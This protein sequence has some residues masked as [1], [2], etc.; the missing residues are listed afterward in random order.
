[1]PAV[2][3]L[4]GVG[5]VPIAYHDTYRSVGFGAAQNSGEL[6]AKVLVDASQV[7]LGSD[8]VIALPQL[9]F[10][11][12]APSGSDKAGGFLSPDLPIRGLSRQSGTVGDI[13][14]MAKKQF[15]PKEFLKGALPKLFG[16]VDL[17]DL[18]EAVTGEPLQTPMVV[19]EALDRVEGLL[20]DLQRAKATAQNAVDEAN[21]LK[22]R[23]ASKTA[24]LQNEAQAAL[25]A[26]Q[27]V[28]TKVTKAV[29][30][31]VALLDTLHD[32]D[33]AAVEAATAAPLTALRKAV[34]EL[35]ELGPKL[36]PL[37]RNQLATLTKVLKEILAAAD[38]IEDLYR[39]LNGFDTSSVQARFRFEWR[40]K[41]KPWPSAS[42][43][44]LGL[45]PDS[46]VLAVEGR[47]SGKGEMGVETLA[48]IR[49]FEL[50][51][52]G[53]TKLVRISFDHLSFKAGSSG[54]ADVDVVIQK[55][56]FV[57]ILAFVE[58]IKELIPFDG[59]SDPPFLD[60]NA[61][62]LT[63]GFTLALPNLSIGVF[64]LSNISLGADV[65]V[66]FLGKTTSVGFNF[67][68]RE[69]PFTLAVAF[70]GGGGWFG[71]RIGPD[72]LQVL[73]LGLEAGAV[74]AIDL[75]VASGSISAMIGIYMRLEGDAGSLTGY[76]RL[77]GEVDVLGL[78]SASIELYLSLTYEFDTGKM[79]GRATITVQVK[80]LFFSGSVSISCE[81]K[82][83][84]SNG[85]PTF[86]E[87]MG[88]ESGSSPAWSEYC[89]AFAEAA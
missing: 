1:M 42:D 63:A 48:E 64:T 43:P 77:R 3:Q 12:G 45:R 51:L 35:E 88:A 21:K 36:P 30:D 10:G 19:S 54:K 86:L 62:G 18:V 5:F 14:K 20:A 78:I 53:S 67:C 65:Q 33:K 31:F 41:M 25:T 6:W 70:L 61:Q 72:R 52:V 34:A 4:S 15:D 71:I 47:A 22:A 8:E 39:F 32:K 82:F 57:G 85:D 38:L 60:V 49:D 89:A 66:P 56:E 13:V 73:E 7:E 79:A 75:G 46:L 27:A 50:N 69:R 81:R 44:I 76:F 84:G 17:V 59:F 87:V 37:I 40:P 29:D 83:A 2:Q 16:L 68:T 24:A 11:S 28:E 9:K 55:N 80:V 58:T 74:L 26:A 23:A